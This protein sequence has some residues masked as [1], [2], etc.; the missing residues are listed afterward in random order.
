[1]YMEKKQID[2]IQKILKGSDDRYLPAALVAFDGLT[3]KLNLPSV[4]QKEAVEIY[5]KAHKKKI[6][7]RTTKIMIAA[8]VYAAIRRS[9]DVSRTLLEIERASDFKKKSIQTCYRRIHKELNLEPGLPD[10][11]QK[12]GKI[13]NTL[14]L[15]AIKTEL[16]KRT[17]RKILDD[18]RKLGMMGGKNPNGLAAAA[19]YIACKR[20]K[21]PKTQHEIANAADIT[22]LILRQRKKELEKFKI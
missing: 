11:K 7:G 1:M 12:L 4:V 10:P 17:A 16:V 8:C 15:S 20:H 9:P 13:G 6:V 2:K 21:V 5:K 19:I 18:A 14:N 22:E 3:K